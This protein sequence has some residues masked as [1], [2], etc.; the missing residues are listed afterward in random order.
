MTL[1]ELKLK[2]TSLKE[3]SEAL[4]P[5]NDPEVIK[6]QKAQKELEYKV[7]MLNKPKVEAIYKELCEVRKQI[8]DL[9]KQKYLEVPENVR[10]YL[11]SIYQGVHY[12]AKFVAKWVSQT[13]RYAILTL[14]G[15][16]CWA[17]RGI[18][19]YHQS[20]HH[21][22]DT[23]PMK[24]FKGHSR[25]IASQ[26]H[27]HEGRLPKEMFETWKKVAEGLEQKAIVKEDY[28]QIHTN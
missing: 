20:E 12:D 26:I 10:E 13:S 7:F 6:M 19:T 17:G 14:P 22:V 24:G 3:Q 16:T 21:L 4:Q 23:K 15:R 18:E 9:Q 28:E 8:E 27:A 1:K 11:E 5:H 2:E 25:Y